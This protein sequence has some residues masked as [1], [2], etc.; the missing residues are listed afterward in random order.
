MARAGP[1]MP[2]LYFR[3]PLIIQ[4]KTFT[5]LPRAGT[6]PGQHRA[7]VHLR[8]S[9]RHAPASTGLRN[10]TWRRRAASWLA[11]TQERHGKRSIAPVTARP[12]RP[13]RV[14]WPAQTA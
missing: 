4:D 8:D 14:L 11:A 1:A 10:D 9:P 5:L 3:C 7:C 6:Q 12:T 2:A 13:A